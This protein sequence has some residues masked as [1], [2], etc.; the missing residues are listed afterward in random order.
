M[1]R[2]DYFG[3]VLKIILILL[4]VLIIYWLIQLLLGMSPP[5][6]QVNTALIIMLLG[7]LVQLYREV[8][9]SKAETKYN[10]TLIKNSF[11]KIKEDMAEI[12]SDTTSL[13]KD[14]AIIKNKLR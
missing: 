12:K 5:L 4:A 8:G 14:M 10:F 3:I 9:D 1:K 7:F 11:E 2:K 6:T 13:K